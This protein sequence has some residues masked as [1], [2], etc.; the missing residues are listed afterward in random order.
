MQLGSKYNI[1][2]LPMSELWI[3]CDNRKLPYSKRIQ[4]RADDSEDFPKLT[5]EQKHEHVTN[6][7][8]DIHQRYRKV[9]DLSLFGRFRKLQEDMQQW[10]THMKT[11]G[12]LIECSPHVYMWLNSN[13]LDLH[14]QYR[15]QPGSELHRLTVSKLSPLQQLE[16]Q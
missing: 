15:F 6:V 16:R 11:S 4:G 3:Y 5:E 10:S 12:Y 9:P 14:L 7:L 8:M 2:G 1:R 13:F